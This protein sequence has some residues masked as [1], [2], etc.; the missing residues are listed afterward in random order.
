MLARRA[1]EHRFV[2]FLFVGAFNTLVGYLLFWLA[3]LGGADKFG[4]AAFATTVGALFNFIS[5]GTVV[6]RQ[7]GLRLLPR[8]LSVY[9]G[10]YAVNAAG[11]A[12]LGSAGATPML[13]QLLLLPLLAGGTYLAMR[14]FVFDPARAVQPVPDGMAG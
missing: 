5:I 10:Q 1:L 3:L 8:F 6:F 13:A 11:L 7:S 12:V 14:S 9:A 4:A 2:R